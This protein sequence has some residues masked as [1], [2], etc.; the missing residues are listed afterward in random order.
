MTIENVECGREMFL[1]GSE[2][3]IN[4]GQFSLSIRWRGVDGCERHRET[5]NYTMKIRATSTYDMSEL[6]DGGIIGN[7]IYK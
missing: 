5:E 1:D 4:V 7:K 3:R 6:S 2:S